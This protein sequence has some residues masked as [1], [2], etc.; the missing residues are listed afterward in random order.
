MGEKLLDQIFAKLEG[1]EVVFIAAQLADE[2]KAIDTEIL[3][4]RAEQQLYDYMMITSGSSPAQLKAI[5]ANIE[6]SFAKQ[7]MEPS[8][9]EGKYG[10]KWFLLDYS[11]FIVHVIDHQARDFYNLEELWSKAHFIPEEEWYN[12]VKVEKPTS[13]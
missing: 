5:A 13:L 1:G 8:H 12:A 2:K 9:K 7:G 11:D 10:D 6:D 4:I 3:D